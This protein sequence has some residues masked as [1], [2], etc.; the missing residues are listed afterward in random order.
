MQR[1]ERQQFEHVARLL[2]EK[3]A[4]ARGQCEIMTVAYEMQLRQLGDREAC[5]VFKREVKPVSWAWKHPRR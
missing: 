4:R 3:L 2:R 1:S 5:Q